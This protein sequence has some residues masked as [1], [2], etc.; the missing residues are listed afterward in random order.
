ML[1]HPFLVHGRSTNCAVD[2]GEGGVRF[3]CH[4]SV[5]LKEDAMYEEGKLSPTE[6]AVVEV[7]SAGFGSASGLG[8]GPV[9]GHGDW[10]RGRERKRQDK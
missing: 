1:T 3:M 6:R 7:W 5:S 8:V 4:P 2:K 10:E 9:Y